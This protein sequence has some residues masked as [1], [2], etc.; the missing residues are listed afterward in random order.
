MASVVPFETSAANRMRP[1]WLRLLVLS[2]V[3]VAGLLFRVSDL[4]AHGVLQSSVPANGAH[5]NAVP[6][7]LRLSFTEAPQL[8]LARVQLTG[9]DGRAVTL[10]ALSIAPE[11]PRTL[12]A[13]IAGPLQ[14]GSYTVAWQVAGA[15]GH[16]VRGTFRF[17]VA[18]GAAGLTSSSSA[19]KEQAGQRSDSAAHH[20]PV[21]MPLSQGAFDAESPGYVVVRWILYAALLTVI[22]AVAFRG[23]VLSLLRRRPGVTSSEIREPAR[24]AAVVG[25]IAA[26]V[27]ALAVVAR[28]V[29]QSLALHGPGNV[30]DP[31]LLRTMV[32]GTGWG[33]SWLLQ[34]GAAVVTLVAFRFARRPDRVT[35]ARASWGLAAVA[36]VALAFS[37]ALGS[38]AAA[39][40]RYST[41]A[42]VVDSLHV[43]GASGWLGSL[44]VLVAAGL[45]AAWSMPETRRAQAV[46]DLVNAFSPTALLFA[47]IVAA[48][49]V[50][51]AWL[52][53]GSFG[54]LWTSSYGKLLLLKLAI[55][56]LVAGTGAY[57]WL[58]V[59]PALGG[60]EGGARIRR[61]ASAELLIGALVLLVTAIL[62]ATPT[63]GSM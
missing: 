35:M 3:M 11:S 60:V 34:A 9:P 7:E 29:A 49:G 45:P 63:P 43:L 58:R 12:L 62:V 13:S 15:D 8:A 56:A 23:A 18:P 39:S 41:L 48:T 52:H 44:F 10:G 40:P 36:A 55:L 19:N 26:W 33:A 21:S 47:G 54:A 61:S 53:I 51:A 24:R 4:A 22:G 28:L 17:V 5:L 59:R 2:A 50:F 1:V 16:P 42:M 57:N 6:R 38:H 31:V 25:E 27:L 32:F 30:A 37:A 14:G 20:A 46:A